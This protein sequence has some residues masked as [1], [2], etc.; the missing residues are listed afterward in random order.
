MGAGDRDRA[1]T[2]EDPVGIERQGRLDVLKAELQVS[3][4]GEK[5]DLRLGLGLR[6]GDLL[7][8]N[9]DPAQARAVFR[10]LLS[11]GLPND[12]I[13]QQLR[14]RIVLSYFN[15]GRFSDA[16]I[17]AENLAL[18]FAPDQPSWHL[19]RALIALSLGRADEAVF[20]LRDVVSIEGRLWRVF[21]AWQGKVMVPGLPWYPAFAAFPLATAPPNGTRLS[22]APSFR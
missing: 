3:L 6:L 8:R 7:L 10:Q 1:G 15:E 13:A 4:E 12:G 19:L 11:E 22:R 5:G 18:E 9:G 20:V 17:S 2:V 14:Q 16:A 21:A